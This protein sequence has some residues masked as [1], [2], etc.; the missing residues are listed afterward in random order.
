MIIY[1][2]IQAFSLGFVFGKFEEKKMKGKKK[3]RKKVRLFARCGK[4]KKKI[5]LME[6]IFS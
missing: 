3:E 1:Y 5:K 2:C 6:N 4:L